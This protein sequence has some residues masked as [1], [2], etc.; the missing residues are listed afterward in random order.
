[1]MATSEL[2][3]VRDLV[4]GYSGHLVLRGVSLCLGEGQLVTLIGPNGHGKTTLLRCISGLLRASSG[5]IV[6]LGQPVSGR[7][8][9]DIVSRGVVHI[10]QGDMLFAD[11]TVADNL[12]MGA[13][14][15]A[16]NA[17]ARQRIEEVYQLLPRLRERRSQ[18]ASTLSG[19]ERRMLAIGRGLMSGG[20][21]MLIDEPSLGLSPIV[22]DQVYGVISN[23]KDRGW[24]ILL[25]EENASRIVEIADHIH[26]LDDGRIVWDGPPHA[27]FDNQDLLETYLGG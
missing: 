10:P 25:V 5:E 24:T 6:F 14:L 3:K 22:I 8:V 23:L 2:L 18:I 12:L 16:A 20:K 13:Y 17:R 27:L 21:L 7:T 11:M 9:N 4:A 15:P 26:L 19:G 1:M